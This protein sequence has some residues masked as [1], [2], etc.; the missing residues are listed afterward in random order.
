M[1][2]L[3]IWSRERT[4][5]LRQRRRR[6]SPLPSLSAHPNSRLSPIV[7]FLCSEYIEI[8]HTTGNILTTANRHGRTFVKA[9]ACEPLFHRQ[10]L[11]DFNSCYCINILPDWTHARTPGWICHCGSG[12]MSLTLF[13][14]T[15][16]H[17][18]KNVVFCIFN[19]L[20]NLALQDQTGWSASTLLE[21]HYQ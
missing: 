4:F 15:S 11:T 21:P 8:R 5:K 14:T 19:Y 13:V 16:K 7:L 1:S 3:S 17:Y 10:W 6:C 9:L 18:I 20:I 2:I 12:R